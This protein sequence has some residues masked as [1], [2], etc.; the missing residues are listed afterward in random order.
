MNLNFIIVYVNDLEKSKA[1]YTEALGM[2]H[3][4]AVSSTTF[5]TM[6]PSEGGAMV[7]LQDKQSSQ[8]PPGREEQPGSVELSFEVADVDATCKLWKE[9]GVEIISEPMDLP[10]GRYFLAKDN[11]GYLS[12]FRFAQR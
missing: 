7:G 10:F 6:R 4:G 5:A 9:K 12:A 3:M 1:F 11:E 8:L 2:T